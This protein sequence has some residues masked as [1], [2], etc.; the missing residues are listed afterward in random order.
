MRFYCTT[1]SLKPRRRKTLN[2][3]KDRFFSIIAHDLRNPIVA[4]STA[5]HQVNKL[6]ERGK[7]DTLKR[8]VGNVSETTSRLNGLLDN[9]L[10]WALSQSKDIALNK[11]RLSLQQL[12]HGQ[13]DLYRPA[14]NEKG[15]ALKNKVGEDI[16]VTAD[17][18]ALQTIHFTPEQ[19]SDWPEKIRHGPRFDPLPG[20]GRA[21][22]WPH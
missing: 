10:K 5:G 6:L 14:A 4:L 11:E 2:A 12:I 9:L 13:L 15:I 3:T 8:V 17:N 20:A 22:R 16:M 1:T 7:T 21:T 19:G 18:D